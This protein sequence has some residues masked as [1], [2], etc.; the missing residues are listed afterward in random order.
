MSIQSLIRKGESE[1]IEFK[2]SFGK[3]ITKNLM[4]LGYEV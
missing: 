3:E 4:E 1:N 2:E